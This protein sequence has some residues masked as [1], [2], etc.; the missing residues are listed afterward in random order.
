MT[1]FGRIV[2]GMADEDMFLF[3]ALASE[4][5]MP[6]P[7]RRLWVRESLKH[8][9]TRGE[10]AT[11]LREARN[12]PEE[13][14]VSYRMTPERFDELLDYVAPRLKKEDTHLRAAIPEAERLAMTIK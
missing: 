14:Y 1:G 5:D 9:S 13:F 12:N 2:I 8:R 4:D 7:K 10:Y 11:L 6:P 3:L